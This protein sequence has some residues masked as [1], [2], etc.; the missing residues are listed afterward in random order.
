[1]H[2]V[3][4]YSLIISVTEPLIPEG[5]L[6]SARYL[7][8]CQVYACSSDVLL[9]LASPLRMRAPSQ[10][11]LLWGDCTHLEDILFT[12][13]VWHALLNTAPYLWAVC[14]NLKLEG[15]CSAPS[16]PSNAHLLETSVLAVECSSLHCA[17]KD[18]RRPSRLKWT[19]LVRTIRQGQLRS[20]N[21]WRGCRP[22]ALCHLYC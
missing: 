14:M 20:A 12:H 18:A 17:E 16:G 21:A 11:A 4:L 19:L 5:G 13:L 7:G 10:W 8:K 15:T 9:N 6:P 2:A 1:M 3:Y 22:P